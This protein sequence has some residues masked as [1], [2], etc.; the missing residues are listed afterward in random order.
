MFPSA[1][2]AD[3]VFRAYVGIVAGVLIGAFAVRISR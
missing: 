3:P 2:L 1:A